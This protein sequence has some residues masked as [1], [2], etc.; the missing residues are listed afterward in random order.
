MPRRKHPLVS[1]EIYHVFNRGINRQRTFTNRV[2][3]RRA[4]T[5]LG[6]YRFAQLPVKLSKLLQLNPEERLKVMDTLTQE[7]N[8]LVSIICF[9]LMPNH[10]HLVLRQLIDGGISKY[11]GNFQNSYTR[12][13]N[14]RND[15]DGSLFL[16]QF[17]AVRIET[18]EQ[19]VHLSR[20]VHLNPFTSYVVK[21]LDDLFSY[22]WSSLSEH[23]SMSKDICDMELIAANFK[24]SND[25]KQF[26]VDQ[27]DY[28]RELKGIKDQILE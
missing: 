9:C 12:Y 6:Y 24:S 13:F 5:V 20:Y 2:E 15:R 10:F 22:P 19:L 16:D 8:K 23:L 1:G 18:D 7:D 28:Q 3:L 11:L 17:K 21:D 26:I 14:T 4:V 27:A 25:Y